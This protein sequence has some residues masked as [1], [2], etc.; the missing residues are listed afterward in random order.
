MANEPHAQR[1][2][3]LKN[4]NLPGDYRKAARCGATTRQR[5]P[6]LGPAMK[7]GRCR[8]H[9]GRSTGP[10]TPEGLERSRRARYRHGVYSR[11]VRQMLADNRRTWRELRAL[12]GEV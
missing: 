11:E 1:R 9:G 7:N 4:G 12:L 3:W 10:T 8:M 6:C 5:T 2:G